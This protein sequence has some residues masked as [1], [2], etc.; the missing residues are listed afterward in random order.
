[1]V[2]GGSYRII[3]LERFLAIVCARAN[4]PR[5]VVLPSPDVPRRGHYRPK[6]PSTGVQRGGHYRPTCPTRLPMG[7]PRRCWDI[8]SGCKTGGFLRVSAGDRGGF[9][10]R[11][12]GFGLVSCSRGLV[13]SQGDTAGPK[14]RR[15]VFPEGDSA[16]PNVQEGYRRID[17]CPLLSRENT[18]SSL[19][20]DLLVLKLAFPYL[21]PTANS[22][23]G[24][25]A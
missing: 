10:V 20:K 7:W 21:K 15:L 9:E 14:S 3:S 24:E 1:M 13:F 16:D 17:R 5:H 23:P 12:C 6:V 22:R 8:S 25:R 4:R 18:G 11:N 2:S 19:A